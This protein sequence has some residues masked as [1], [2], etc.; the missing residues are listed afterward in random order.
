M[1]NLNEK[2]FDDED[3]NILNLYKEELIENFGLNNQIY[4]YK[5]LEYMDK[6]V[7]DKKDISI[8]NKFVKIISNGIELDFSQFYNNEQ[9]DQ[10]YFISIYY[11]EF[12]LDQKTYDNKNL[13]DS[14]KKN[15]PLN[16]FLILYS[17]SCKDIT[18]IVPSCNLVK[19]IITKKTKIV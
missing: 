6:Q 17:N 1:I 3:L 10:N 14:I 4:Y 13:I 2:I 5:F 12:L 16:Y 15:I 18:N 8:F 19:N 7:Q 11:N 9:T